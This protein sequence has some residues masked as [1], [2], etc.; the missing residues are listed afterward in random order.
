MSS[1]DERCEACNRIRPIELYFYRFAV[2]T[3]C[4]LKECDNEGYLKRKLG[5][6]DK[7]ISAIEAARRTITELKTRVQITPVTA[8]DLC[9]VQPMTQPTGIFEMVE[10]KMPNPVEMAGILIGIRQETEKLRLY[11]KEHNQFQIGDLPDG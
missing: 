11:L 4:W 7:P 6:K 5:I 1:T 9:S 2:C 10:F 3:Q 8:E